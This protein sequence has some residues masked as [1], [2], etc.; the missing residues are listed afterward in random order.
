[1]ISRILIIEDEPTD[2]KLLKGAFDETNYE[3]EWVTTGEDALLFVHDYPIDGAIV[4]LKL[5]NAKYGGLSFVR[6]CRSK[7]DHFPVLVVTNTTIEAAQDEVVKRFGGSIFDLVDDYV[8]K[9]V[10]PHWL[11]QVRDRLLNKLSPRWM[12]VCPPFRLD[13]K[14]GVLYM[15]ENPPISL[16]PMEFQVLERLMGHPG[17][18][19]DKLELYRVTHPGMDLE[20]IDAEKAGGS[21]EAQIK[22]LRRK[23]PSNR[24]DWPIETKGSRYKWQVSEPKRRPVRVG[25]KSIRVG[26]Y[27]LEM[28]TNAL[29]KQAGERARV[30]GLKPIEVQICAYLMRCAGVP[31]SRARIHEN[32]F[33]DAD[34]TP[35]AELGRHI[36]SLKRKTDEPGHAPI[37]H[38]EGTGYFYFAG[39]AATRRVDVPDS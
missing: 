37:R 25:A 11:W 2:F 32:V 22:K 19:V 15:D 13:H 26:S 5:K 14:N 36:W 39:E 4:D 27:Q 10:G 38:I 16:D 9:D 23:I 3:V 21:I 1:M 35:L 7:G 20:E 31:R 6:H 29:I 12:F 24:K 30:I 34:L 18:F 33:G 28:E 8:E 17:I